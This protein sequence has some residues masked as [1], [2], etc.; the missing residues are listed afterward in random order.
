M[1]VG[2]EQ[3]VYRLMKVKCS[4][5]SKDFTQFLNLKT[6][7]GIVFNDKEYPLMNANDHVQEENIYTFGRCKSVCNPNGRTMGKLLGGSVLGPLLGCISAITI[8]CKCQPLTPFSWI[9][10]DDDYF[11][12]GAPALTVNSV[13]HCA[14]GGEITITLEAEQ[15]TDANTEEQQEEE[16]DKDKDKKELLPSE[17]QEKIDSF[18]DKEKFEAQKRGTSELEMGDQV[19]TSPEGLQEML[20][21]PQMFERYDADITDVQINENYAE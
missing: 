21:T 4:C 2:K 6:D 8:G 10:T 13:L 11:I 1:V 12:D 7:H 16:K 5:G 20:E 9:G 17:V 3:Y 19:I 18:V 14:Y 15:Q